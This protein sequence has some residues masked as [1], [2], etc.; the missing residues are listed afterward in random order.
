MYVPPQILLPCHTL[1][2]GLHLSMPV[3]R[4]FLGTPL[5]GVFL[6]ER[7]PLCQPMQNHQRSLYA[8]VLVAIGHSPAAWRGAARS[9][10]AGRLLPFSRE[11]QRV[12]SGY[13]RSGLT[14]THHSCTALAVL[15]S[16][17]WGPAA[18]AAAAAAP[19][20][21]LPPLLSSHRVPV[22]QMAALFGHEGQG[23]HPRWRGRKA[24]R[25]VDLSGAGHTPA[26]RVRLQQPRYASALRQLSPP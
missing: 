8:T 1:C 26:E 18:H 16:L 25:P 4:Q 14:D 2:P 13:V 3:V 12:R 19:A 7:A 11:G 23:T 20:G 22:G 24:R 17:E 10:A 5:P 6:C 15:R 9:G 21:P